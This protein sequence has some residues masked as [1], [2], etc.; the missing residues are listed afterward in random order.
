ME[1]AELL[2]GLEE[3][4][5]PQVPPGVEGE[6]EGEEHHQGQEVVEVEVGLLRQEGAGPLLPQV[7]LLVF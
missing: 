5:E 3:G 2:L 1:G 4:V 6:G 7:L